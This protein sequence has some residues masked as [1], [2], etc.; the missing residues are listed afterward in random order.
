MDKKVIQSAAAKLD[1]LDI[2]LWDSVFKRGGSVDARGYPQTPEQ[3]SRLSVETQE[4][5]LKEGKHT[6]DLLRI[7]VTLGIRGVP[8]DKDEPTERDV[9]FTIEATFAAEYLIADSLSEEETGEFSKHNAV[10]NVWPFWRHHVFSIV[11]SAN[12]PRINVPLLRG[13]PGRDDLPK[14]KKPVRKSSS[15]KRASTRQ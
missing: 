4:L 5:T 14:K 13:V 7:L 2:Y 12:L 3:Q 6:L 9:F 1:L 15:S 11:N 10:H 8:E